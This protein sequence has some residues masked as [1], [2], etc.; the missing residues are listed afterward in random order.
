MASASGAANTKAIALVDADLDLIAGYSD[1]KGI[2]QRL[3]LAL[4]AVIEKR[5]H[6][7]DLR[8]QAAARDQD[9]KSI[10]TDQE[11]I[12]KNMAALDKGSSLYKRYVDELIMQENRVQNLRQEAERLRGAAATAQNE[13]RSFIDTLS[14]SD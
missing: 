3:R 13:L 8:G 12:R 6:I 7:Q 11:R 10:D 4:Q 1:H 5:R 2:S 14:L 9:P